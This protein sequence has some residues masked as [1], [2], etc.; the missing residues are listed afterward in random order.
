MGKSR[1]LNE[2]LMFGMRSA[3]T[4][5]SRTLGLAEKKGI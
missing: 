5:T 1:L 3:S 4:V 2:A